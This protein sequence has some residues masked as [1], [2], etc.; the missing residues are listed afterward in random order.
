MGSPGE[1]GH[2]GPKVTEAADFFF[3][4]FFARVYCHAA[5]IVFF[6]AELTKGMTLIKC[7]LSMD[8][9]GVE[10]DWKIVCRGNRPGLG[11]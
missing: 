1:N 10:V 5:G 4:F 2:E 6:R 3:F 11:S 9:V 8:G 7:R